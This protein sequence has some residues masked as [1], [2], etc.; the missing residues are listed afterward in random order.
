VSAH[1]SRHNTSTLCC[2][3]DQPS[4]GRLI[5]T[6][7]IRF[8]EIIAA[9]SVALDI[10]TGQ[11]EGHCMRTA[12]V[13]MKL[14]EQLQLSPADRSALFYALLLKD[15]GCSSNAAKISYLFGADDHLIKRTARM[16]DWTK[17]RQVLSHCWSHCALGGSVLEKLLKIAAIAR[18]GKKGGQQIAEI[19]C[20]RGAEI[21]R[22]LR[23]PEA[24]ARA[25]YDLDEHWD[26]GGNAH[27][28]KGD[29]ITLLGRICCLSQTVEVF[30]S[31][32]GL[33]VALDVVQQRRGQWF[34]PELVSALVATREDKNF[35][36]RM[37]TVDLVAELGRWEPQNSA[38]IADDDC[39][40]RVAEAFA[41][42]VDAKSPWTYQHSTRV[43]EITVG[44]AR[45]L[46]CNRELERDLRRAAL[47]HDIGKLGVSNLILDKAGKP[48]GEE[49]EAIKRHP[50]YSQCILEQVDGFQLLAEVCGAHHERLDGKGYYR[51]LSGDQVSWSMRVLTIA[52]ACE[53]MS[54]KRPYRDAM[55]WDQIQ[56]ILSRECGKGVD[57]D[58]FAALEK[59]QCANGLNSR[60]EAQFEQ[61]EKLLADL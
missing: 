47:L 59:W 12:L 34:D 14:A 52:D 25:I 9:F 4:A 46:G 48:T 40:D 32:Y 61:V 60:V 2:S 27:G 26:G 35:W 18:M 10:T 8:S 29:E 39:L 13:G 6:S 21:A 28:L 54:A 1:L 31:T 7:Q 55:S 36:E 17:P 38:L 20:Q 43:A 15:L 50:E 56:Q 16:I 57:A 45:Q 24:T 19:R 22:L 5:T 44:V 23:L 51:G 33:D 41:K 37:D 30:Y 42:V 53:A 11:P 58:C 3:S 49:F